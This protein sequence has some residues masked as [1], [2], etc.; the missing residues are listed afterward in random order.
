M[1]TILNRYLTCLA[2]WQ[3]HCLNFNI[4]IRTMLGCEVAFFCMVFFLD[5]LAICSTLLPSVY[6]GNLRLPYAAPARRDYC[7][8]IYSAANPAVRQRPIW[9]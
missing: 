4:A 8:E 9:A 7:N 1:R 6:S 5:V 2:Q 3:I